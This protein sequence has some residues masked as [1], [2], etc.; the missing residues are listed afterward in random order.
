[1]ICNLCGV[2]IG[3][4]CS[5]C[6]TISRLNFI[7]QTGRVQ[8][9]DEG[10]ALSA[11]RSAA[12]V[13]SDLAERPGSVGGPLAGF[14]ARS[15]V[16]T[17]GETGVI[18]VPAPEAPAGTERTEA[19]EADRSK[20]K[21]KKSKKDKGKKEKKSEREGSTPDKKDE[22]RDALAPEEAETEVKAEEPEGSEEARGSGAVAPATE[23]ARPAA[24]DLAEIVADPIPEDCL[25]AAVNRDVEARPARY[26]LLPWTS[27]AEGDE[28]ASA[29]TA[30]AGEVR[31]PREPEG[32]PPPRDHG[33]TRTNPRRRSR[34]R[35]RGTKGAGH[36][37]RGI[38]WKQTKAWW[39]QQWR[40]K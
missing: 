16:G 37:D 13:L 28:G 5:C 17:G 20:A 34:S 26:G 19:K 36:R 4:P 8:P 30:E 25:G 23:A 15:T 21:E 9:R 27:R 14:G 35:R 2:F 40:R 38:A 6:R 24:E 7:L 1:M 18:V 33:R 3:D 12:G 11:L 10:A 29:S 39:S 31:E 22:T 32:P